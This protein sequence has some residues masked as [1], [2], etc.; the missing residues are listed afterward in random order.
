MRHPPE[1]RQHAIEELEGHRG[2]ARS[3]VALSLRHAKGRARLL[4]APGRDA[5]VVLAV[6]IN[7]LGVGLLLP[8]LITLVMQ[9]VGFDQRGRATGGFTS[10]IFAGEFVSPLIVLA[11]TAGVATQLPHALLLVAI[12]QL[13]L[14]PVCL[15]LMRHRRAVTVA[16]AR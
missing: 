13:L 11:L 8:T 7:G 5:P 4:G 1:H 15:S 9:Q 10:A 12:G 3:H 14:A 2:I 16:G 6:L